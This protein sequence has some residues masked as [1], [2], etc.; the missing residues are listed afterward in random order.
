MEIISTK[1]LS[2]GVYFN[3]I[4]DP[5]FKANQ[6]SI[7]FIVGMNSYTVSQNAIVPFLLRKHCRKYPNMLDL[8]RKLQELYGADLFAGCK[9]IG[10]NQIMTLGI[11]IIDDS[12][13]LNGERLNE[14][15]SKLLASVVF[16]PM[17]DDGNFL[18]EDV[19]IE[20]ENL[21]ELVKSEYNDKRL[22][23]LNQAMYYLFDGEGYGCN[24]YGCVDLIKPLTKFQ[25]FD[26]YNNLLNS[27]EIQIMFIGK[28]NFN[29]SMNVFSD[30]FDSFKRSNVYKSQMNK[31]IQQNE[32]PKSK[33]Q[34]DKV[35]QSKL[36]MGFASNI[37]SELEDEYAIMLMTALFGGTPI[38][39]LFVNVREKLSL[40]YYCAARYDNS[41]G[42]IWVDS[43]VEND[44][45]ELAKEAILE[46]LNE[47]K[48][49]NFS[50]EL[51][52]QT[53]LFI[54]NGL[55][56]VK[57][58]TSSVESYYLAQLCGDKVKS[59]KEQIENIKK[60][61]REGVCR[62]AKSYSLVIDYVFTAE[63]R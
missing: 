6:I 35:S 51:L 21:I 7:N 3:S 41:K 39:K 55:K 12:L 11:S 29:S 47:L 33:L 57:D 1:E 54:M 27:A 49:G 59:P 17:L 42:I 44:N 36:V 2:K 62:A 28:G 24:K 19:N 14:Q 34:T 16:E 30:R 48:N 20:K 38:S 18:E 10:D 31:Y 22:Y 15:A 46:Q 53:A 5:R 60:V 52:D 32:K 43:G 58:S 26:A 4:I 45:I 63:D 9:K 40:C 8:G 61:T 50:D 56:S 13:A 37:R 25:I 23:A